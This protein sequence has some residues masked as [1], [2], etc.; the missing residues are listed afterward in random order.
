MKKS[1]QKPVMEIVFVAVEHILGNVSDPPNVKDQ[2]NLGSDDSKWPESGPIKIDDGSG[3]GVSGA[4]KAGL[5]AGNG[6]WED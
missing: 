3:P 5:G 2:Y 4:K 1:Y 6:Y